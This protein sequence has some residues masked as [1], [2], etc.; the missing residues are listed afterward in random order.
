LAGG[1]IILT[2]K[3]R[4]DHLPAVGSVSNELSEE[5]DFSLLSPKPRLGPIE[6]RHGIAAILA[7]ESAAVVAEH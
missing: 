4:I 7:H 6:R 2:S 1:A 3:V 5:P